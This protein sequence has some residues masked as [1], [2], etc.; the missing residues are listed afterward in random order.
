MTRDSVRDHLDDWKFW[1][2]VAYFGLV[3]V[4]VALWVG[5][6]RLAA[7]QIR[8]ANV[9]AERHAD[10]I[11]N[12]DAQY[13]QCVQSI[14]TL[15]RVNTFVR[16]VQDLHKILLENSIASHAATPPGSALYAQQIINIKRLERTVREV[17]KVGFPVPTHAQC[18]ALRDRLERKP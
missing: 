7:D 11:A 9:V 5:Y 10:I 12:A 2:G 1:M 14:P 4:T 15:T 8:T 16:G 6:G 18:G 17:Q 3:C 13:Q